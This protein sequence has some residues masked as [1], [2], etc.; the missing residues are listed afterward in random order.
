MIKLFKNLFSK[1]VPKNNSIFSNTT[2]KENLVINLEAEHQALLLSY[3][4][5]MNHAKEHDFNM[6]RTEL[7]TFKIKLKEHLAIEFKDLYTFVE[8][9]VTDENDKSNVR[10]FRSEMNTIAIQVM[11]SLNYYQ[12]NPVNKQSV[13]EFIKGFEE[14]GGVL[15]DRIMREE[16]LLYP[17]YA[18]YGKNN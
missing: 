16:T 4:K 13:N 6:L 14:I 5:I 2:Y 17:M 18:K 12:Q 11:N 15:V 10:K 7:A 8:F 3:Q 1:K 9:M